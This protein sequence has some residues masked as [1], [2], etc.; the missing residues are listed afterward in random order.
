[1]RTSLYPSTTTTKVTMYLLSLFA[2]K[3]RL[4]QTAKQWLLQCGLCVLLVFSGLLARSQAKATNCCE[5]SF[6]EVTLYYSVLPGST[7]GFGMEGG[8]WNKESSR[9]SYFLGTRM[10]WYRQAINGDKIN[11]TNNYTNFYLYVKGQFRI[12]DELFIVATPQLVNLNSFDFAPG[13]RY[14]FPIANGLGVGLEPSYSI[15]Q[16]QF[17][18]NA[19]VHIAL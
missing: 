5:Q 11:S 18:L 13:L 8:N 9:F 12:V 7:F 10:Q 6:G 19:N 16:K 2:T 3:K 14:V 15:V 4:N 1:M 17:A